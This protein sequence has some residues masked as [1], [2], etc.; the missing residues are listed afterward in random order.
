[1]PAYF[2]LFWV[3]LILPG[4]CAAGCS[5]KNARSKKAA[6]AAA[7]ASAAPQPEMAAPAPA[8]NKKLKKSKRDRNSPP[9][10]PLALSAVDLSNAVSPV[11]QPRGIQLAA[12][13]NEY[14]SF[15]L[16]VGPRVPGARYTLHLSA[17]ERSP[18][19]NVEV[20]QVLSMAVDVN[21]AGYVRHTGQH[22]SRG[23]LPRA[24]LP[25]PSDADGAV[26]LSRLRDASRP[27]DAAAAA[28][29]TEP[30]LL[31][32]DVRV[33]ADAPPGEYSAQ[34]EAISNGEIVAT[35][36]LTM[37]VHDFTLPPERHL[38]VVGRLDWA[39][40]VRL[41][42]DRFEAI[43]A[44]LMNRTDERHAGAVKVIDTLI[45]LAHRHR[46]SVVAP[47]LQPT[48][49]WPPNAPPE[50]D[51][52]DF[53]SLVGPWLTGEAFPDRIPIGVWPLPEGERLGQ[54]GRASQLQYW[55]LAATHF[56]Q[57]D[58]LDR[59]PVW[60]E[61]VTP[62]KATDAES[63]EL[64]RMAAET[65]AVHNR[66][67][68]AVPLE[69]DQLR[70]ADASGV[71]GDAP[72][73]KPRQID[74]SAT[75]RLWA[76]APGLVSAPP[77]RIWPEA[78]ERPRQ[79]LRTDMP[80][81]VPYV[82]AGGDERDVRLWAWLAFLRNSSL[83]NFADALPSLTDPTEPADPNELIWFYPGEWFG[84]SEP[85]PTIQLKWLRRAQQDYE[86]L[87][88][89]RE[90]GNRLARVN[91]LLMSQ[92]IAK[93]V[94]I[95][96]GQNPDP[97]YALMSGTTNQA[98]WDEAQ[99]LL[100]QMIALRPRQAGAQP[101][102][103]VDPVEIE[104]LRWAEPQ[105]RPLLMART[106]E[107]IGE[108]NNDGGP[109]L[110]L[111]VGV[112]IYNA[113]ATTPE[114]NLLGWTLVPPGWQID[115]QPITVPV[116]QTYN[117]RRAMLESV[118]DLNKVTAAARTPMEMTFT[119]GHNRDRTATLPV[120]LPI[121][122]SDRREGVIRNDG[123]LDD[124]WD[125]A[126]LVHQGNLVKMLSRPSLQR[127]K[128]EYAEVPSKVYTCWAGANFYVAFDL[129]G[130]SVAK[131]AAAQNFVDYQF[132][133]AWGQDLC[134]IL[135]QPLGEGGM[136][137]PVLHVVCK[138]NGSIWVERKTPALPESAP[139]GDKAWQE[140]EGRIQ[141]TARVEGDAWRGEV[142]IPW[143]AI[144]SAAGANPSAEVGEPPALMRFNF[145][146]HRT[147]TGESATWAGPV[148]F[149]R[150]ENLMGILYLRDPQERGPR[151]LAGGFRSATQER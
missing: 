5:S 106:A 129:A 65:L 37:T 62:G 18:V 72:A 25:M 68:V 126:D 73:G 134:E 96:P 131:V 43:R 14:A 120:V 53:D 144:L 26:D 22:A 110:H 142:S 140:V 56:D 1:M 7:L 57:N 101:Q 147:A 103:Q 146:Q 8:K 90:Q 81:L 16:Q 85:V 30:C 107:W 88:L 33:P 112:D 71:G 60:V 104:M 41:Y 61:K 19:A 137:G 3:A 48:V 99:R 50:V 27:R 148:D 58:W 150:D 109:S 119:N 69:T 66:V 75:P 6:A 116:L 111:K 124:D 122:T 98:V 115:P 105:E 89:A 67:R 59:A 63:A 82:G 130:V 143:R 136:P 70:V 117:V 52:S 47:G 91:T 44:R 31:W 79:Y 108:Q 127:Q 121:A 13:R 32:V 2:R 135:L 133:R 95:Q 151:N 113:S 100:A 125:E 42:P 123:R 145:A 77:M 11:R 20:S 17:P 46:T 38:Q 35:V 86:Y 87:W 97:S 10:P 128:L 138:P 28:P 149:G 49:K 55:S 118:F 23:E 4:V 114:E 102:A 78:A 15:V 21:R 34:C 9:A 51:W 76:A 74:P 24:L 80:A 93:P 92:L 84:L 64:S 45:A 54:Y 94:E 132:R 36:P 83:I 12:A 39:D 141:Y 29:N 139:V 40:L